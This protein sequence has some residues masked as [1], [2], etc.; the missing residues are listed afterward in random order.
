MHLGEGMKLA[1]P[2][3][4]SLAALA[5]AACAHDSNAPP[6][7]VSTTSTTSAALS[8]QRSDAPAPAA[9]TQ[10][11]LTYHPSTDAIH[12]DNNTSIEEWS[13]RYPDASMELG[14]W[15][16][17]YPN[18]AKRMADWDDH[19]PIRMSTIVD[20]A[21]THRYESI[22]AFLYGRAGW[23]EL[24]GIAQEDRQAMN[25]LIDWIRRSPHAA[26]EL[27]THEDSLGWTRAHLA[28]GKAR[29]AQARKQ[30]PA[31]QRVAAPAGPAES[32]R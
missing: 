21:V 25:E 16:E 18:A 6:P 2:L 9:N 7:A 12:V 27:V 10:P 20:W 4:A 17:R 14:A 23:Q 15:M 26:A 24:R 31:D 13:D 8:V 5:L 29:N 22:E 3:M 32:V 19:H 1:L 11:D 30:A 28:N